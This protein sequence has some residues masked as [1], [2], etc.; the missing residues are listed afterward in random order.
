MGAK[1]LHPFKLIVELLGP[2][3]IAVGQI[4]RCDD[5]AVHLGLDISAM[6]VVGIARQPDPA[7]LGRAAADQD[8]DPVEA[9]LPMPH[10]AVA[11]GLDVGDRQLLVGAFQFL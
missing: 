5:H 2:D 10:G 8:R 6:R 11:G 3:R 7:Q 9:L 1:P 4:E